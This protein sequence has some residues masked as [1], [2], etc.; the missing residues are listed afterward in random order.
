MTDDTIDIRSLLA[1]FKRQLRLIII[2]V[3]L[4]VG[5]AGIYLSTSTPMYRSTAMIYVDPSNKNLL[6]P[7]QSASRSA[8]SDNARVESEVEIIRSSTVSLDVVQSAN[9]VTDPEFGPQLGRLDKLKLW[10]GIEADTTV[11]GARTLRGVVTRLRN[12][13]TVSRR[14]LTYLINVTVTSSD[15]EKAAT[16]ANQTANSY[17]E[18]QVKSKISASLASQDILESQIQDARDDLADSDQALDLFINDNLD[19]LTEDATDQTLLALRGSVGTLN[20]AL[21]RTQ[22][23]AATAS[24]AL[25]SGDIATLVSALE[26]DVL[27]E[28][29]NQRQTIERRLEEAVTGSIDEVD[30][31]ASLSAL[32]ETII[33]NARKD[34]NGL[35]S[36]VSRL[37]DQEAELRVELRDT[38]LSSEIPSEYLAQIYEIQQ[39]STIAR[40]QYQSLLRSAR[41]T[42]TQAALQVADSRIVSPATVA[43]NKSSPNT[44]LILLMAIVASLGVGMGLAFLNEFYVGGFISEEQLSDAAQT[45]VAAAIPFSAEKGDHQHSLAHRV[46]DSPLSSYPEAIRRLRATIDQRIRTAQT[47]PTDATV[48]HTSK[49]IMVTSSLPA[50]GKSTTALSLARTY[51]LSGK[52][53]L[54][55]DADLRR[56]TQHRFLDVT[57]E[58][59]FLDYLLSP[60]SQ[61]ISRSFYARDP[62]TPLEVILGRGRSQVPTD[63]LLMSD[64]FESLLKSARE[65]FEY[66]IIDTPP[67]LPVVD[68]R[69]IVHHADAVVLNVRWA[70]TGQREFREVL[71]QMN[72]AMRPGTPVLPVLSHVEGNKATTTTQ[73][74]GGYY[75]EE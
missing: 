44:R 60:G 26:N 23:K 30:L 71:N 9:L 65:V 72:E 33:E 21:I 19:G 34:V 61:R 22:S 6:D 32:D 56:P 55:I 39:E 42:Q 31:R 13:T 63:Q 59:G 64:V 40:A 11:D 38:L 49:V 53:T 1:M 70:S 2:T 54:L 3:F 37:Q 20:D 48:D 52:K 51:A 14:G 24:E 46:V 25:E 10:V 75:D 28:L 47:T 36:Q 18:Q 57:P 8:S 74:Y 73:Y 16:L 4:F 41:D 29:A 43:N 66:V 69:Y 7:N 67:I 17:I 68:G 62:E 45:P 12:A 35:A 5:L 50:E 15:P 58:A 27:E